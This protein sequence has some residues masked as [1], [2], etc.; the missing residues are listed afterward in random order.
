MLDLWLYIPDDWLVAMGVWLFAMS[1]AV[2]VL[3]RLRQR[4]RGRKVATRAVHAG[5]SLWMLLAVLTGC[6]LAFALCVDQ[7]DS[8]NMTNVSK[9]WMQRHVD[10]QT[11]AF[12]M[13]DVREFPETVSDGVHRICFIGD[14]FTV[15]HGVD[16][17]AD[18][19]TDL[20]YD[21]LERAHPGRYTVSNLASPG[22]EVSMVRA[23]VQELFLQ[24][25][26]V[27]TLIYVVCLND[28]EGYDRD[29]TEAAI[30]E[31]QRT[32][33]KSYLFKHTYFFN[34]LYYRYVQATNPAA[35]EY[36]PHLAEAWRSEPSTWFAYELELMAKS[37]RDANAEF[38]VVVFP[39]MV[40]LGEDYPFRH[41]HEEIVARCREKN[42]SVLD[43]LPM[44]Q[45]HANESLRVSR[46]D[47]HPNERAHAIAAEAICGEL[48][49][50]YL[51]DDPSE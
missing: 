28:V 5:L 9:R 45:T 14:S 25:F 50:D 38:R 34:W 16:D 43:L 4:N 17:P 24:G 48:L 39:F 18:R 44:M 15:G 51:A 21:R 35:V 7:S 30:R 11:N 2:W 41:A 23:R 27:D 37:C 40:D 49:A 19:F 10:A 47:S 33:P 3:L 32:E 42:I 12:G 20:T 29:R 6:E 22:L 8:F 1:V 31:L 26:Q 46:F 13:R 36:F